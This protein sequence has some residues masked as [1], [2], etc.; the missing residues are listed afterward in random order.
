MN[1]PAGSTFLEKS[2]KKPGENS[3]YTASSVEETK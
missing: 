3:D 1:L 2:R